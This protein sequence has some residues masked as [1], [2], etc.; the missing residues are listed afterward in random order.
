MNQSVLAEV[1]YTRIAV[2]EV[3]FSPVESLVVRGR[4]D[5]RSQ[6]M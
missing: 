2:E 5:E 6:P 3:S 4:S 1:E